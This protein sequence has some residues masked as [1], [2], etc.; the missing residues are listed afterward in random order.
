MEALIHAQS[1]G[2][3]ILLFS[4]FHQLV[5]VVGSSGHAQASRAVEN[6]DA[7]ITP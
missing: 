6:R 7:E 1:S 5:D 2:F 3:D 4:D